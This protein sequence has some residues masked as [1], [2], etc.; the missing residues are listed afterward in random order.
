MAPLVRSFPL[1]GQ[2][3]LEDKSVSLKAARWRRLVLRSVTR[4]GWSREGLRLWCIHH[5]EL[6]WLPF[7]YPSV[8]SAEQ[9]RWQITACQ[10][11]LGCPGPGLDLAGKCQAKNF[12]CVVKLPS[13]LNT[14]RKSQ[15]AFCRP[16][17]TVFNVLFAW[18]PRW[19][20][21]EVAVA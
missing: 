21:S 18:P 19:S 11:M 15:V 6:R 3:C 12:L 2:N 1:Q 4:F 17:R 9:S 7:P 14:C 10:P 16:L 13:R 5:P 20:A 8:S